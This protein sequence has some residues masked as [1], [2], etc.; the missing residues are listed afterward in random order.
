MVNLSLYAR[1]SAEVLKSSKHREFL[2]FHTIHKRAGK[3]IF[4]IFSEI[5]NSISNAGQAD[6]SNGMGTH[7]NCLAS[8]IFNHQIDQRRNRSEQ[9]NTTI[10][11]MAFLLDHCEKP[12]PFRFDKKLYTSNCS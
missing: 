1:S 10:L 6:S 2:S 12:L 5:V 9:N 3:A 4:H 8:V 7:L 11:L